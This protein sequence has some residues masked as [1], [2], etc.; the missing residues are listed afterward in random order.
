VT[1]A[2]V[3]HSAELHAG[4]ESRLSG[5]A[6]LREA[7]VTAVDDHT[8]RF[9]LPSPQPDFLFLHAGRGVLTIYSKA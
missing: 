1:A 5:V 8:V 3:V 4:P 2:D 6:T 7:T 9:D